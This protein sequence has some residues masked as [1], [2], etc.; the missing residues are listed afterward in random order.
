MDEWG[1][2]PTSICRQKQKQKTPQRSGLM[3]QTR[4]Q[5][6]CNSVQASNSNPSS[7]IPPKCRVIL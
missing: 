1:P 2:E 6:I 5:C 4:S 3:L 7:V